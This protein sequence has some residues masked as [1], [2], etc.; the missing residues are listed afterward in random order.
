MFLSCGKQCLVDSSWSLS[1]EKKADI[2]WERLQWNIRKNSLIVK[3]W[4]SWIALLQSLVCITISTDCVCMCVCVSLCMY[5]CLRTYMRICVLCICWHWSACVHCWGGPGVHM[6]LT[7]APL[8]GGQ[9]I[10][11]HLADFSNPMIFFF[12]FTQGVGKWA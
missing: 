1:S 8:L 9:A 12:F 2:Q 7:T 6:H 3:V 11:F 4:E 10:S 5:E